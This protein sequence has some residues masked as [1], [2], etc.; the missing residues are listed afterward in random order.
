MTNDLVPLSHSPRAL[1]GALDR[2]RSGPLMAALDACNARWGRGAVVPGR[3]GAGEPAGLEHQVRDAHA[4]L[5][6]AGRRAAGGASVKFRRHA[7]LCP[8]WVDFVEKLGT[9]LKQHCGPLQMEKVLLS[10]RLNTAAA[11]GFHV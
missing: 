9:G 11:V 10:Y 4:A 1:I 3:A 7:S 5:Y 8:Q 6:D 2:G